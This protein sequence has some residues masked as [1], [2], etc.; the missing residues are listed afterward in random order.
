MSLIKLKLAADNT[1]TASGWANPDTRQVGETTT[2]G[3]T[4]Y[5][6]NQDEIDALVVNHT[7][8]INNHLV[9][10]AD[11][12]PPVET[13]NDPEPSDTDKALAAL[14]Y[15][16]MTTTQ[17]VTALQTQNAQMAYQLMMIQQ[18]GEA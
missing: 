4:I 16:Q 11:Y 14:S 13:P 8:L 17:D 6:I 3:F 12:V 2:D 18:G 15:Q 1:V 10:D 5:D 7:K 9:I